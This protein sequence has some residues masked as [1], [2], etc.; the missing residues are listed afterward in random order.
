MGQQI[1]VELNLKIK[2]EAHM[3]G[4]QRNITNSSWLQGIYK[5]AGE[6]DINT[7][8]STTFPKTTSLVAQSWAV[9]LGD[10]SV[11]D[12]AFTN[13]SLK[14][15]DGRVQPLETCSSSLSVAL[16]SSGAQPHP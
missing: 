1:F 10:K 9:D 13:K 8:A 11:T 6:M 14:F 3:Q 2:C 5:L 4:S 15:K 16:R 7:E 12:L